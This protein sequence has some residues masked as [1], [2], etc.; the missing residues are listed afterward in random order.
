MK[1]EMTGHKVL[2]AGVL[3]ILSMSPAFA[4]GSAFQVGHKYYIVSVTMGG[5][6]EVLILE[7]PDKNGWV[8]VKALT[9]GISKYIGNDG[10]V[11][12]L[13]YLMARE[14]K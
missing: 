2:L 11:N 5:D 1:V 14:I 9:K 12:L 7:K 13:N 3:I 8:K 6:G 4:D 10:Y